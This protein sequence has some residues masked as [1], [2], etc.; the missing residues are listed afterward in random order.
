MGP[1]GGPALA[2]RVHWTMPRHSGPDALISQL[3][4]I[5][6]AVEP[7]DHMLFSWSRCPVSPISQEL[8]RELLSWFWEQA[9]TPVRIYHNVESIIQ[10]SE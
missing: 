9:S 10:A 1:G 2:A 6:S 3:E 5:R 4:F 7:T 8:R